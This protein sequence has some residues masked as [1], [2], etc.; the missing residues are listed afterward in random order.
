M[1]S[2]AC[3]KVTVGLASHWHRLQCRFIHLRAH[4]QDREMSTPPTMFVFMGHVAHCTFT[5]VPESISDDTV[6]RG[7]VAEWLACW[8]QAQ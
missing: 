7:S 4:G 5:F 3:G 8:T 2:L 6:V 1:I